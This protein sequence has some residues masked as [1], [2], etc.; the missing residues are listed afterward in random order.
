MISTTLSVEKLTKIFSGKTPFVAVREVSFNVQQAEIVGLLGPNGAGKST[1]IHML[2]GTLRPSAGKVSYFGR[3]LESHRSE[4]LEDVGYVSGYSRLPGNLSVWENLNVHG[5]LRRLSAKERRSRIE[6]FLRLFG[7]YGMRHKLVGKL[8]AGENTRVMLAK[9]FLAHPKMVLL[10]EPTAA[11][12]PDIC[13]EVRA[14]VRAQRREYG[15][16][17][18]YTSH[19]MSE[20]AEVCDRVVFL[21]QG[22]VV[23]VDSPERLAASVASSRVKLFAERQRETM[24]ELFVEQGIEALPG[25]RWIE[26]SVADHEF[27]PLLNRLAARGVTLEN[28]EVIKPSLE[29]FFLKISGEGGDHEIT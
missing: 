6:K 3:D 12:D 1:T 15:V 28:I 9:A 18:I 29:D 7:M 16:S 21:K 5:I 23:A 10:D 25:E 19:N 4:I 20:V 24:L 14:F 22:S 13:Q 11:L 2:L 27:G 17:M 8:S 26:V